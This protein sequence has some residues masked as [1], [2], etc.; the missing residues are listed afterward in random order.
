MNK[1]E[2][3]KILAGISAF[4]QSFQ[5]NSFSVE[6]W[7]DIFSEVDY[8]DAM[9]AL[10]VFT[11][12][13]SAFAPSPGQLIALIKEEKDGIDPPSE[14]AFDM[15]LEFLYG[16]EKTELHPRISEVL[17]YVDLSPFAP[18][19][20]YNPHGMHIE[21]RDERFMQQEAKRSFIRAYTEGVKYEK[22]RHSRE[23]SAPEKKS[24]S[25]VFSK[26]KEIN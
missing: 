7:A 22:K 6:M 24:L 23:L 2:T 5:V 20:P 17:E 11:F 25:D 12:T 14:I 15:A 19:K 13:N 9:K 1:S 16:K 8:A 18:R 3:A 21:A 26:V 4:Y 10:K